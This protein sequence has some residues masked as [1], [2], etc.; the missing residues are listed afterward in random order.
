MNI[1]IG[2]SF[3]HI[4]KKYCFSQQELADKIGVN[5]SFISQIE[6]GLRFPSISIAIQ[7]ADILNCSLDELVGREKTKSNKLLNC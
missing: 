2:Q 6:L 1:I 4:R 5:R 3:A 7:I